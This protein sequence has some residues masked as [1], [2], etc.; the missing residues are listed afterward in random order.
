MAAMV[1]LGT[2]LKIT[3]ALGHGSRYS[4]VSINANKEYI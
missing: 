4:R 1:K 2:S 3:L